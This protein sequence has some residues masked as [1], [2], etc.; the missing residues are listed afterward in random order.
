M[1]CVRARPLPRPR[2]PVVKTSFCK[3]ALLLV[4]VAGIPSLPVDGHD[5][6]STKLTWSKEVSRV[7]FQRCLTCHAPGGQAFSLQ[8]Y[9]DARPWAKAIQEEVL[10]RRMPPWNAVKGFGDF[11]H[12][13]GLSQEEI[14]TIADWVEGGAPE[15][16]S[17]F[18]PAIPRRQRPVAA[19]APGRRLA[20][21]GRLQL[22]SQ[23]SLTSIEIGRVAAGTTFKLV[24]DTPTGQRIP[25]I[26]ID[27]FSPNANRLYL[28]KSPLA[29]PAG[30]RVTA[31]PPTGVALTLIGS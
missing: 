9:A 2:V 20:L 4:A 25:L 8:N 11:Q 5:V 10:R 21:S 29:L 13:A 7:V 30:T 24:A 16:D 23:L 31:F 12:D 3:S 27:N 26:W 22:A 1:S 17:S 14:H 15:G 19:K 18:L 6:V 28:L